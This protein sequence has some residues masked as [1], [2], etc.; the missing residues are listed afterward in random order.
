MRS[1]GEGKDG[2]GKLPEYQ[3]FFNKS[4]HLSVSGQLHLECAA[5]GLE[6]VWTCSPVFR[7][8]N[9]QSTRHLSEFYMIEAEIAFAHNIQQ[10]LTS[11]EGLVKH[12]SRRFLTDSIGDW[13]LQTKDSERNIRV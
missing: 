13:S 12:A 3:V 11:I 2:T 4:V 8:E 1:A 7:A 5:S 9:N 6:R 10:I